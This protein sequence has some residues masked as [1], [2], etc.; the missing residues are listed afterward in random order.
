MYV[1][2]L[3]NLYFHVVLFHGHAAIILGF[4]RLLPCEN[5]GKSANI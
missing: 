3:G 5:I 1:V 4:E 2:L